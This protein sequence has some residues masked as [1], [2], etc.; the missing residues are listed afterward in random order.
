MKRK[1]IREVLNKGQLYVNGL[2]ILIMI[3]IWSLSIFL[4]VRIISDEYTTVAMVVGLILGFVAGWLYW[5]IAITRWRI[6]A[7]EHVDK[8]YWA[9]LKHKA[10]RENLIWPDDSVFSK[11]ELR[12][13]YQNELISRIQKETPREVKVITLDETIDDKSLPERTDYYYAKSEIILNPVLL[14]LLVSSG[15]Y[16][17]LENREVFAIMSVAVGIYNFN[18]KLFKD[19]F[20]RKKQMSISN[21][22]IEM[23]LKD[24][25]FI[26]WSDTRNIVLDEDKGVLTLDAIKNDELYNLTYNIGSFGRNDREDML[27]KINIYIKRNKIETESNER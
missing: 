15:V 6:W 3:L 25:G 13:K 21:E 18:L 24:F 2:V 5:S 4:A 11:T 17:F 20:S 19:L 9:E 16:L 27:R 12:T 23:N 1:T 22:G 14:I 10:I 7:F 26:N 8:K